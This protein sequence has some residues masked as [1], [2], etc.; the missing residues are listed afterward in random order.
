LR[1]PSRLQYVSFPTVYWIT[2]ITSPTHPHESVRGSASAALSTCTCALS[3]NAVTSTRPDHPRVP[4]CPAFAIPDTRHTR[5][6]ALV[7]RFYAQVSG[8]ARPFITSNRIAGATLVATG[9][10]GVPPLTVTT[11]STG[12]FEFQ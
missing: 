6:A 1:S 8:Y 12:Q 5:C 10:P 3:C 7:H 11:N 9:R 2:V 4:S